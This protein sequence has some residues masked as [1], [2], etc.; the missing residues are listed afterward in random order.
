MSR[1]SFAL[2]TEAEPAN[3]FVSSRGDASSIHIL[4]VSEY[5]YQRQVPC[6]LPKSGQSARSTAPREMI[7]GLC[8]APQMKGSSHHTCPSVLGPSSLS[9]GPVPAEPSEVSNRTSSGWMSANRSDPGPHWIALNAYRQ[10]AKMSGL[11]S[12]PGHL[13]CGVAT[14]VHVQ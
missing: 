8:A 5:G 6:S 7:A 12:E 14:G 1:I 4:Q 11:T 9:C 10:G 13:K 2:L 3:G